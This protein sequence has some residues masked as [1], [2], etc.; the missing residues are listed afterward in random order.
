MKVLLLGGKGYIGTRLHPY[1]TSTGHKVISYDL[2]WFGNHSSQMHVQKDINSLT[3]NDLM[4]FDAVVLLAAH[5][6]VKMCLYHGTDSFNNN[7]RNF[8][9][10]VQKISRT[11]KPIKFIYA[12]SSSIY[13]NTG[14]ELATENRKEFICVN[15]Y[16]LTK[17]VNDQFMIN[18]DP[19]EY[20]YGLRFGTVNGFSRNFRSE[21][22]L[23]SMT[24]RAIEQDEI[25]IT[26]SHINRAILDI[27]D[28]CRSIDKILYCG[29]MFNVGVYNI[30]SFNRNVAEI[31]EEVASITHSKI[32]DDGC[33]GNPYDFAISNQKFEEN[34][35]FKFNGSIERIVNE[36]KQN[37]SSLTPTNRDNGVKY[38]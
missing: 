8:T 4:A 31:A 33:I 19:L 32:I 5:S 20:W 6:S 25:R 29:D 10:L 15:N 38:E 18:N 30:N 27:D 3:V 14:K 35:D 28:L 11:L 26:N 22:M 34:F 2:C 23:N 7:V 12:S 13:G 37:Y 16:D 36:I 17:Y 21:L 24:K 1:L 9:S